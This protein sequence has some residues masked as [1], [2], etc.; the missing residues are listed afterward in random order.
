MIYTDKVPQSSR[1][2]KQP[3][4][5]SPVIVLKILNIAHLFE[6]FQ[7]LI[8]PSHGPNIIEWGGVELPQTAPGGARMFIWIR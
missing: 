1:N 5:E 8:P 2:V 3:I 7:L 6:G 4:R